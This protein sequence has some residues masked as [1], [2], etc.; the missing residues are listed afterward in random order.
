MSNGKEAE[1]IGQEIASHIK[2]N[3]K[4]TEQ[5]AYANDLSKGQLSEFLNGKRDIRLSTLLKI[6]GHLG[7]KVKL[8]K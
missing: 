8:S 7:L 6:C 2:A 1:K 5:F 4:T 3:Y